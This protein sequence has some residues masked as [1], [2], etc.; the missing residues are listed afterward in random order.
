[1]SDPGYPCNSNLLRVYGAEP[2]PVPV[3][4]EDNYQIAIKSVEPVWTERIRGTLVGTPSNPTGTA[5]APDDLKELTAW[6]ENQGGLSFVDE[7]YGELVYDRPPSTVL[8]DTE[9]AFV[10]NSFSKTFGMTGWRLGW[11]VCPEWAL[12]AVTRLAQNLY[13]SPPVPAQAGGLA[14]FTAEVWETVEERR[15]LFQ[16]RRDVLVAGLRNIGFGVPVM[17]QGAFYVYARCD[18]F[19][20]DSSE[21]VSRLLHQAGVALAPGDDFGDHQAKQHVRF[22]Y[23]ASLKQLQ[24]ALDLLDSF[25]RRP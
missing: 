10:I 11:L 22:S 4:P 17:P 5:L 2:A 3:G 1:M 21:L 19:C 14:A 6:T 16:Q 13:I 20:D 9:E 7:V 12:D 23:A 24:Q 25:L 8:A 18:A 15:R